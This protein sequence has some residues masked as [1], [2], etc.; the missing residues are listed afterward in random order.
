MSVPESQR[1]TAALL[2]RLAG[3]PPIETHISLVFLGSDIVWKLKKAV[4]LPFLDFTR[5]E[6][7]HRFAERELALNG[8]AAPGLYRDVVAVVRRD[9]GTLALDP[10]AAPSAAPNAASGAVSAVD[11]VLRMARVPA[12]DF[13]DVMAAKGK[14]GPTLQDALADAV[15]TY[16]AALPPAA[17]VLPP[18]RSVALGNSRA[19]LAAGLPEDTVT[20]WEAVILG[21]ID[22]LAPWMAQR[23]RD[24]FVRR[25][26]G[27]LHLGNLCLWQG[28]PMPFDALE[29]DESLATI[30]IGYDLA[31]LLMDLD[32]R[33]SRAAANRVLN[34]TIARSA[35]VGLLH[36][37]PVFLSMRAMVRAHV[38]ARTGHAGAAARYLS[39][40]TSYLASAT[41]MLLAVGGLPGT[42]KSTLAR[43]LAP[44]LGAAPGAVI[45]RSDE[46][47][48]RLHGVVPEQPLPPEAYGADANRAVFATLIA[49]ADEAVA[50]GH[51]VIADATFL[52]PQYRARLAEVAAARAVP[53]HGF[54]LQ[55]PLPL[56]EARVASRR[57]D[58]SDASIAVLRAAAG[59]DPGAG[60]WHA[61]DAADAGSALRAAQMTLAA[62]SA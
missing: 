16:H 27:D 13:L 50:V 29:F 34:R 11:W 22:R 7:R 45:L 51:T 44:G 20:A 49:S 5:V 3:G 38:E 41:P 24:G 21:K 60:A 37:L 57:G 42:G 12:N 31:F 18:M 8:P 39:A 48:K 2:E 58:A 35:D 47:R 1:E 40:A 43:A 9:D 10:D 52:D 30:D 19:A 61:I 26:H 17:G 6:D 56:L 14:L 53:F 55:A 59:R 33:L 54:W 62:V 23:A 28:R 32:Q 15:F 4:H 46:I 36:A 25:A